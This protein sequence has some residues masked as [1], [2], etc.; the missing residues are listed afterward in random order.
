MMEHCDPG[1]PRKGSY[2]W[3]GAAG[4]GVW[5]DPT[6]GL[7]A[8]FMVQNMWEQQHTSQFQNALYGALGL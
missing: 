3:G 8:V 4:T 7:I 1:W 6:E 2:W 5:I